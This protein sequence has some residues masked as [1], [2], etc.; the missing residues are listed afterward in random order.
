MLKSP[1]SIAGFSVLFLCVVTLYGTLS[2]LATLQQQQQQ[3]YSATNLWDGDEIKTPNA[4]ILSNR[5]R[6]S[7]QPTHVDGEYQEDESYWRSN[8][9]TTTNAEN[10]YY[11]W[12][13]QGIDFQEILRYMNHTQI[14]FKHHEDPMFGVLYGTPKFYPVTMFISIVN[15][16]PTIWAPRTFI[17][18]KVSMMTIERMFRLLSR[19]QLALARE[20]FQHKNRFQALV[21]TLERKGGGSL[22]VTVDLGDYR[23]CQD[24]AARSPEAVRQQSLNVPVFTNCQSPSCKYAFPVPTLATYGVV[25]TMRH[26]KNGTWESLMSE[27]EQ[28]F[29]W[30]KKI[31]KVYWRGTCKR[32]RFEFV[33]RANSNDTNASSM[34]LD[35][36]GVNECGERNISK[37][38][39]LHESM[40]YKAVF[41]IDGISWS[42]R[43]SQL[44]CFNS[45][46]IVVSV[47]DDYEEY[48]SQDLVAGVHFVPANLD[49]FIA[50]ARDVLHPQNDA[51][52]RGIVLNANQ[53]CRQRMTQEGLNLDFLSVLNGYVEL[54]NEHDAYWWQKWER[55]APF[56]IQQHVENNA[57]EFRG[58]ATRLMKRNMSFMV[59]W[60]NWDL[61]QYIL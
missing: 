38:M 13:N 50:V 6:N 51:F 7:R 11:S 3:Q 15:N 61:S 25:D 48:F 42:E 60:T 37:K 49:N 12:G 1:V 56:Y 24:P 9:T 39:S 8:T 54:L 28:Q 14:E 17:I 53:W 18:G 32:D 34:L 44:L 59:P 45:A 41:D 26:S 27:W 58:N 36:H 23:S 47:D 2:T 31:S 20:L 57:I 55:V 43:F 19:F 46:V 33:K 52:L 40:K 4:V 10:R 22:P 30:D 29:P 35:I 16:T 21:S 5:N